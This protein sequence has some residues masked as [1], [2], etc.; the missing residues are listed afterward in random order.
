MSREPRRRP[1]RPDSLTGERVLL[2][3]VVDGDA[4]A[5]V[6]ILE[7]PEIAAIWLED[8]EEEVRNM[9]SPDEPTVSLAI[10]VDGQV[11]GFVQYLDHDDENYRHASIDIALEPRRCG[12]GL[13]TDSLRTL[14]R[15]LFEVAGHHRV[16]I[17]PAV[18]NARAIAS[19]RKVGFRDVGVMRRYERGVDGQW[20]DN[21][22]MDLLVDD[23][24]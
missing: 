14:V 9:L 12:R 11:I 15:W 1:L 5:I 16:T 20:H 17:D 4:G 2:R 22:L 7:D 24:K 6:R 23:L 18:A 10:V 8:G 3:P 21:L 19:Y 13:G